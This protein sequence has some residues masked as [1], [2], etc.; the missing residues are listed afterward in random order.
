MLTKLVLQVAAVAGCALLIGSCSQQSPV[1]LKS[2]GSNTVGT[3]VGG[4]KEIES[5]KDIDFGCL[6][7]VLRNTS[8]QVYYKCQ[9][10]NQT[11]PSSW[12][13]TSPLITSVT[14]LAGCTGQNEQGMDGPAETI[15]G[16][17]KG[18]NSF[19]NICFWNNGALYGEFEYDWKLN[20]PAI[21]SIIAAAPI[22]FYPYAAVGPQY[23]GIVNNKLYTWGFW[24][25]SR[26]VN[27]AL[28][29]SATISAMALAVD[30][31]TPPYGTTG[32]ITVFVTNTSGQLLALKEISTPTDAHPLGVWATSYTNLGGTISQN[33]QVSKNQAGYDEVFAV[34]AS[35]ALYH[36]YQTSAT[37]WSGFFQM[38]YNPILAGSGTMFHVMQNADGRLELFYVWT[39]NNL[40]SHQYQLAPN[41]DWSYPTALSG[42]DG[43]TIPG[44]QPSLLA[45]T[46]SG[47]GIINVFTGTSTASNDYL[48][49]INQALP[50]PGWNNWASMY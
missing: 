5:L 11:W 8:N 36:T 26:V 25:N 7:L 46:T 48:Y 24:V 23:F 22:N 50:N 20:L 4:I 17:F 40:V 10:T 38:R 43:V 12:T 19:A 18:L 30:T 39:S 47:G 21:P 3:A 33:I 44:T 1:S 41:S 2:D 45:G 14:N 37:A 16:C 34:N 28:L 32:T 6:I 42:S 27:T 49:F 29:N 9:Y 35:G 13:A 31:M 15:W